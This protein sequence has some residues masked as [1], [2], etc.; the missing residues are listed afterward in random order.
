MTVNVLN[1]GGAER[2]N[3]WGKGERDF[4]AIPIL[5][6]SDRFDNGTARSR[7]EFEAKFGHYAAFNSEFSRVAIS[8]HPSPSLPRGVN[9]I[10]FCRFA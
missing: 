8:P 5:I 3:T 9:K 4:L 2:S 1:H 7:D 6:D 10:I